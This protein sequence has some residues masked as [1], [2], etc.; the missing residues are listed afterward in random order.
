M[1]SRKEDL[2][3]KK[4]TSL[5]FAQKRVALKSQQEPVDYSAR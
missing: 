5:A 2:N 4:I 1:R 3:F